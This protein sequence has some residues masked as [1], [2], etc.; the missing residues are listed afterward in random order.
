M[1]V[2]LESSLGGTQEVHRSRGWGV[3]DPGRWLP[4]LAT[5]PLRIPQDEIW[6]RDEA[7]K[8]GLPSQI[9]GNK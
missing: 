5:T 3:G 7:R 4:R 9:A 2:P 6:F 8:A 1:I